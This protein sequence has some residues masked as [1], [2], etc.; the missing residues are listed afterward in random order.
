MITVKVA[1]SFRRRRE[2]RSLEPHLR[3][4][5]TEDST[6][7]LDLAILL[8]N[9]VPS[10]LNILLLWSSDSV[11]HNKERVWSRVPKQSRPGDQQVAL[12][13]DNRVNGTEKMA[14]WQH[15]SVL[16]DQ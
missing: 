15:F 1:P 3:T 11:Q 14:I 5:C 8:P 2:W 13:V 4:A 7:A 9:E 10:T 16:Q 6:I 12:L